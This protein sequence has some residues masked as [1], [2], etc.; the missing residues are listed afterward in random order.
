ME[1]ELGQ[2]WGRRVL[3][4]GWKPLLIPVGTPRGCPVGMEQGGYLRGK[5]MPVWDKEMLWLCCAPA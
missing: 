5:K 1:Q 4:W 3:Y 2:A